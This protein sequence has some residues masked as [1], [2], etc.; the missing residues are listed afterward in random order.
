MCFIAVLFF[1]EVYFFR[2]AVLGQ[3]VYVEPGYIGFH[4]DFMREFIGVFYDFLSCL[5]CC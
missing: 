5:G 1:K 4:S 2:D 3:G